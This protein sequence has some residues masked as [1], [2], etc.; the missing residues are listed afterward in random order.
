LT[1]I[2]PH[3]AT[4]ALAATL[5]FSAGAQ[6]APTADR[7]LATVGGTEI[8]LGHVI[9][10]QE[11]LPEQYKGLPDDQ[12]LKGILDQLVQQAALAN[13]LGDDLSNRVVLGAENERRAFLSNMVLL[14]A[15]RSAASDEAVKTAYEAR[16]SSVEPEA[17][18]NAAHI[19]VA[20]EEEANALVEELNG[21]ADFAELAKAKS[22]GP[23]G[24]NGGALGWFGKG[25]MVA[26][27]ETAVVALEPGAVSKPVQTQF[28]WHVIKLNESRNKAAP[29]LEEVR[30]EL[31]S[32]IE[33]AAIQSLVEAT[34]A[35]AEIDRPE[36]DF[37]PA[38]IRDS[39]LID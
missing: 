36:V 20:T 11:N 31:T 39:S 23:S 5:S 28:G 22:T 34:N 3:L 8:T 2:K 9:S 6:E 17:E 32:E 13:S 7:V 27:F 33:Q 19:L 29:A 16:Y 10:V 25:M 12:L 35:A 14:G 1:F 4:F 37:D 26:E 30:E 21:G 24:P 15:A 38:V 18:Y